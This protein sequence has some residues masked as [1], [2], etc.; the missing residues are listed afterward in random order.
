[1]FDQTHI[2]QG[3]PLDA[4]VRM[5]DVKNHLKLSESHLYALIAAGRFPEPFT[6]IPGGKARGW[7][8][9]TIEQWLADQERTGSQSK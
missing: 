9:S 8:W 5:K 2:N 3:G 6:L 7:R 1:M 4:I